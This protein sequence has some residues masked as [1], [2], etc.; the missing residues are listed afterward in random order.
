MK[1]RLICDKLFLPLTAPGRI[2]TGSGPSKRPLS[3]SGA[4]PS[5]RPAPCPRRRRCLTAVTPGRAGGRR[6]A[7]RAGNCP[8][9]YGGWNCRARRPHRPVC[10]KFCRLPQMV[11]YIYS[12][13]TK[14]S[15]NVKRMWFI[16]TGRFGNMSSWGAGNMS[17]GEKLSL[18]RKQRG[19]T[20]MELAEELDVSRQA[21]SRWE[22]ESVK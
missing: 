12:E 13:E 16:K 6:C 3:N 2:F 21:V 7:E 4:G 22:Q 9:K 17:F 8:R 11:T 10:L 19:M 18:L 5:F 20:Q 14:I 15:A 1:P